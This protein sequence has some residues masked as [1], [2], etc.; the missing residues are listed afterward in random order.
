MLAACGGGGL[1]RGR[2]LG[3]LLAGRFLFLACDVAIV[4]SRLLAGVALGVGLATRLVALAVVTH[5]LGCCLR[6][7]RCILTCG[8]RLRIGARLAGSFVAVAAVARF[9]VAVVAAARL[10]GVRGAR[11]FCRMRRAR[12]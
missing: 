7:G 6:A 4:L 12:A 1:L 5:V 3:L 10:P 11:I 2:S 9:I 8:A